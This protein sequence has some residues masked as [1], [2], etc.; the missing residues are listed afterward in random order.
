MDRLNKL[1][2]GKYLPLTDA[3]W[4]EHQERQST[5][6]VQPV[7]ASISDRQFFEALARNGE[8]TQDEALEA[9]GTGT[10]PAKMA[11]LVA[12]MPA[13]KQF[14]AKMRLRGAQTFERSD[15]TTETIRQLYGWSHAQVDDLWRQAATL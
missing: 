9:V 1:V 5:T 2:D 11:A 6:V 15:P 12:K 7:P 8:I 3:E 4:A 13:D 10:L 14:G